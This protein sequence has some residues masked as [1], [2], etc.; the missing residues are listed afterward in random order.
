MTSKF[1]YSILDFPE[2]DFDVMDITP[3]DT[4]TA[5]H[6]LPVPKKPLKDRVLAEFAKDLTINDAILISFIEEAVKVYVDKMDQRVKIDKIVRDLLDFKAQ[7][8]RAPGFAS[9]L[10]HKPPMPKGFEIPDELWTESTNAI[11]K[12]LDKLQDAMLQQRKLQLSSLADELEHV[13]IQLDRTLK[14]KAD[15][16]AA[17]HQLIFSYRPEQLAAEYEKRR[18]SAVAE[19]AKKLLAIAKA[20]EEKDDLKLQVENKKTEATNQDLIK[21]AVS[22]YMKNNP[23]KNVAKADEKAKSNTPKGKGKE[24]AK[25]NPNPKQK[26]KQNQKQKGQ[27]NGEGAAQAAQNRNPNPKQKGKQKQTQA[28]KGRRTPN[29]KGGA[30]AQKK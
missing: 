13:F 6:A 14:E 7:S 25:A 23:V 8:K 10:P 3:N 1:K 27:G 16:D 29:N 30:G 5:I 4:V 11:G 17:F 12:E 18:L 15:A 20:K 21:I 19:R 22:E 24:Q 2:I 26:Q 9:A 28:Q